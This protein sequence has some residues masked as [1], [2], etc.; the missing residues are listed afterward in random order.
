[1]LGDGNAASEKGEAMSAH[2]IPMKQW[3]REEAKRQFVSESSIAMRLNRGKYPGMRLRREN[4]RVVF[5]ALPGPRCLPLRG[6]HE[7]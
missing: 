7:G 3:R 1:M 5:V 2:E 4:S 6:G